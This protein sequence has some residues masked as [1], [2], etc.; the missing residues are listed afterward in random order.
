[1][2]VK[3]VSMI[4]VVLMLALLGAYLFSGRAR[5][6]PTAGAVGTAGSTQQHGDR[7]ESPLT[8]VAA[9]I[10]AA[11]DEASLGRRVE[12]HITA[13]HIANEPSFWLGDAD[14]SVLVVLNRDTRSEEQRDTGEPP[15]HGIQRF[16]AG[17]PIVIAGSIERIPAAESRYSW[18]INDPRHRRSTGQ[19]T[20]VRADRLTRE[21]PAR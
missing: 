9:V 21:T 20:Y 12:L 7:A 10:G 6:E 13:P 4:V 11:R 15:A 5:Q 16:E 3:S 14:D 18:G 1:M 17:E 8:T 19:P 2:A